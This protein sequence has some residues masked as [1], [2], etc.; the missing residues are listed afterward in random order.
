MEVRTSE[1]VQMQ[2]VVLGTGTMGSAMTARLLGEGVRVGVWSRHSASTESSVA[3]GATAY[4]DVEEAAG[5]ADVVITMLPTAAVTKAVMFEHGALAAMRPNATWIQMATIGVR[6]TEQI[7]ALVDGLRPD[8][9]L[10][11]APVSGSRAPAEAGELLILASSSHAVWGI[12]EPIFRILG[13]KTMWLGPVGAGSRM[14]LMLNTLLAFQI[15][16]IAE[17]TAAA[18][19]LKIDPAAVTEALQDSP[20]AS[21]YAKAKLAKMQSG[22]DAPEFS[23]EM[24]LKDLDLVASEAGVDAVPIADSISDR[25][26]DLVATGAGGL[27]VSAARLGLGED[28]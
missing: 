14:K 26:R 5:A 28:A 25:W 27:D 16:G 4:A 17:V 20:L 13:R 21:S 12:V 18:R 6:A 15:E 19:R 1:Q 23:L 10:I 9:A 11:D 3:L 7:A 24:A 2:V 22:D 8:V